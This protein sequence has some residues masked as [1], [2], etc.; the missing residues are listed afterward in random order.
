LV[1][2]GR[3]FIP[4]PFNLHDHQEPLRVSFQTF[5]TNCDNAVEMVSVVVEVHVNVY[6]RCAG[7]T[8]HVPIPSH[9]RDFVPIPIPALGK[10]YTIIQFPF[11]AEK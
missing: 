7:M 8:F 3:F 6:Y 2:K 9:S 5:N 11:I 4:L 10:S 1:Q